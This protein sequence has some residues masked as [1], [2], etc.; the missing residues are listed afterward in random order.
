MLWEVFFHIKQKFLVFAAIFYRPLEKKGIMLS[1]LRKTCL[2]REMYYINQM[3]WMVITSCCCCTHA[4]W[5]VT[6]RCCLVHELWLDATNYCYPT[7]EDLV[8]PMTRKKRRRKHRLVKVDDEQHLKTF[9]QDNS[10][11]NSKNTSP[12]AGM[13]ALIVIL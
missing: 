8:K 5:L 9:F 3:Y 13:A 11:E 7:C 12:P 6:L 4:F 2:P 10:C 1:L